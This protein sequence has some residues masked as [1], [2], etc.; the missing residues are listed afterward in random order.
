[1]ANHFGAKPAQAE[2]AVA[3]EVT[4]DA[5]RNKKAKNSLKIKRSIFI[6]L[7]LAWPII[8]MLIFWF[9]VHVDSIFLGFR[10]D[11]GGFTLRYFSTFLKDLINPE[12]IAFRS[13]IQSLI[14]AAFG[15]FIAFP[16]SLI[17]AYFMFKGVPW[18]KFFRT[19]YFLPNIISAVV[20]T[21]IYYYLL[22]S[23]GPINSLLGMFDI[24]PIGFLTTERYVFA[25][26]LFYGFWT[27][28]GMD[29]LLLS[30]A[31]A[32]IP[33]DIMDYSK[34]EGVGFVREF[35][36]IILPLIFD[37]VSSIIIMSVTGVFTGM[38]MTLLLTAGG[39]LEKYTSTIGYFIYYCVQRD[40]LQYAA[41]GGLVFSLIA[42]PLV[43]TL[44]K[45]LSKISDGIEF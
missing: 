25:S 40:M 2:T 32:R 12:H 4:I 44:R 19:V 10:S 28:R 42:V 34:L 38:G 5:K 8:H 23:E 33:D 31:M 22:A 3:K 9:Y 45:I 30:G 13:V 39:G 29:T 26:C 20:M 37:T 43:M 17:L 1:M 41:A 15:Q 27:G 35:F 7:M 18:N 6:S 36:Q 24:R 21:S 11:A 16:T 14:G